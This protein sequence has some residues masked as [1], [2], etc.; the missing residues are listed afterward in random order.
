MILYSLDLATLWRHQVP[1]SFS[2]S[3]SSQR[4]RNKLLSSQLSSFLRILRIYIDREG[5]AE[6]SVDS[7]L[8]KSSPVAYT[9]FRSVYD[10]QIN[11]PVAVF[12]KKSIVILLRWLVFSE[13]P[14]IDVFAFIIIMCSAHLLVVGRSITLLAYINGAVLLPWALRSFVAV[15]LN[16]TRCMW[17]LADDFQTNKSLYVEFSQMSVVQTWSVQ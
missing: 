16:G 2:S 13:F 15:E 1:P 7:L 14:S 12:L 9:I 11:V 17:A 5:S 4:I 6:S 8:T 10:Y 3:C